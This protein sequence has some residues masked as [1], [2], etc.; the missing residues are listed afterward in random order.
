MRLSTRQPMTYRAPLK[1]MLFVHAANWRV[2]TRSRSCRASRKRPT[3]PRRRCSRSARAS[4]SEVLAPLNRERRCAA[5]RRGSDGVVTTTPGFKEAFRQFVEGGWQGLQHPT[6]FGGQGLPKRRRAPCIEMLNSAN[7]SLR[8]VPAADRRRDRGAAHGRHRR[9]AGSA[10]LPK[11]I[12]GSWTGT[13]NLTEPQAGS[14]PR[15]GAHP[16][17]AAGRRQLPALRARRSSSPTAST[18]WPRTSCTS[19]SR[20][21][22][23]RPQGSRASRCSSCRSSSST[24]TAR[25]ASATTCTASRS[26]TSSA[27]RPARPRC[28]MFGDDD[29]EVGGRGDRTLIGEENRGLEYMF[30]MMNAARFAVGMQGIAIAERAYQKAAA[31]AQ[32]ARAESRRSTARAPA[33]VDDHPSPRCAAHADDDARLHRRLRVRWRMWPRRRPTTAASAS[34]RGD[35]KQSQ[36]FYEFMVPLVKGCQHRDEHRGRVSL[37]VQVHGGMG[38]IEETGAAQYL[39]R[40]AHPDDLR[41]HDRDPGERP[42]RPQDR[43]RRRHARAGRSPADRR[44]PR[45]SW[46]E[47][48]APARQRARC[49]SAWRRR[50]RPS[51]TSSTSSSRDGKADPNAVFAGSVPYLMLAGNVLAG[52]QMAR[53]LLAAEDA[54]WPR[55]DG[56]RLPARRR[57]RPRAST[58]TTCWR[59]R[60]ACATPSSTA[61]TASPR[62]RSRPSELR[63]CRTHAAACRPARLPLPIIGAPLFIVSNPKLVIAQCT[64]GI[65]G[66]MPA[67]NARPAEQLDEWLAEITESL[68]AWDRDHP[69]Q[70]AAP[71][72]INQIV[73]KSNDRLEHDMAGL[74]Q[75]PGAGRHHLARRAHR[76]QRRRARLGRHR[77]ARRHQRPF[78]RKAVEKGADG[79]IAVAAGAGGHAGVKSPFALV[80]EI[81]DWFDGPL[82]LS[83]A[84]AHR[85]RGRSPRRPWAPT[86][87]T[88]ARPSSPPTRRAPSTTTSRRSSTARSDD[89]VYSSLFTGVHGN[90]LKRVDPQRRPRPRQPA[91]ER[92][93]A[94]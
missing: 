9:A 89:I 41:R 39:P 80:Q 37:G 33:S 17:G 56:D 71:F 47:R 32:G 45:R 65:V 73:H 58:P 20:A 88:S 48:A 2:S 23:A 70:P 31:F 57:S 55:G 81:R 83:G 76:R 62:W 38:F 22:P 64:A 84:I 11:M 79:L 10:Y 43:A 28:C 74:R 4:T 14:R 63:R 30:I 54:R 67:L 50:A 29:G 7:L 42:G 68:A 16:R 82:A 1:D 26:S 59:R 61:P 19:C 86:S 27:S 66:S 92:P 36:A 90:Y 25:S 18:T 75:L 46:R 6:E 60:R 52:W 94:R 87:P 85:R 72:A 44:R 91:R 24:P 12:D 51:S 69:E 34:G 78:A 77:A 5:R 21:S 53:A 15:A 40:R 49:T 3:R 93:D 35:A 8:A 13:M